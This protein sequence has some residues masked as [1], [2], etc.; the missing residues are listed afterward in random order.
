MNLS[1]DLAEILKVISSKTKSN[2]SLEFYQASILF[3]SNFKNELIP[4][5]PSDAEITFRLAMPFSHTRHVI[6]FI[7][8]PSLLFQIELSTI[9]SFRLHNN[10]SILIDPYSNQPSQIISLVFSDINQ[11][12]NEK[13]KTLLFHFQSSLS[14]IER[15][16]SYIPSE[17]RKN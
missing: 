1:P 8:K 17:F 15:D 11:Q 9:L 4:Y 5:Y 16:L 2:P 14:Q 13:I 12:M 3:L 6:Q 10:K 7:V